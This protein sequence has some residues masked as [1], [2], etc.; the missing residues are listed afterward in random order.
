MTKD[1][2]LKARKVWKTSYLRLRAS[3]RQAKLQHKSVHRLISMNFQKPKDERA[4]TLEFSAMIVAEASTL[5]ELAAQRAK[6]K[7]MLADL[8]LLKQAAQAS[9]LTSKEAK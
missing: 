9:Y 6:M 3:I 8:A 1:L 2:Y 7:E 4:K 5:D